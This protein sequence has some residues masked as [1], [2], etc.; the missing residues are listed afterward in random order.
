MRFLVH[1]GRIFTLLL[2]LF[3]FLGVSATYLYLQYIETK[4]EIVSIVQDSMLEK[5]Y[6]LLD[7]YIS[8][9]QDEFGE[10]FI[11]TLKTDATARLQAE[12]ALSLMKNSEVQFL[13]L[14]YIDE[15][16]RLRY[17]IDTTQGINEKGEYQQRFFPQKPIWVKAL[18]SK[19]PEV[20]TQKEIDKLWISMA[21]PIL[22][23]KQTVALLGIDFSHKEY[24]NVKETL[25]PLEN[26][27][28]YSALFIVIMLI[29]AFVQL[30]IY[31]KHRKKSFIDPL[32]G[33]FNRQY[34][35]EL[36]TKYA[37][38]DF[39][40]LI[41][42]L[43]HFKQVNDIYGHDAGD[44]VLRTVSSRIQSVIRKQD[45]LIRYGGEEFLLLISDKEVGLSMEIA[46][47]VR[48]AVK[49]T[50]I[51]LKDCKLKVTIS[52]GLNPFPERSK[53]FEQAVK[54]ADLGLYKAKKLGRDRVEIYDDN[55][56]L[57]DDSL[58]KMCDVKDALDEDNIF[59]V[60]QAIYDTKALAVE[61]YELLVRMK[62]KEGKVIFPDKFLPSIRFTQVYINITKRVLDFAFSALQDNDI[63][64]SINLDVQDLFNDEILNVFTSI[65]KT[66]PDIAKR[67]NIEI[68]VND[69]TIDFESMSKRLNILHQLGIKICLDNFGNGHSN[70]KHLQNMNIDSLKIDSAFISGIDTNKNAY[71]IVK[72]IHALAQE[73]GIKT[74]AE[75]IETKEEFDCIK[76]LG[77]DYVQGYYLSNPSKGFTKETSSR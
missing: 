65:F 73:L 62:D 23:D 45:I 15:T 39:Q 14:L 61:K 52:M 68:L 21:Y 70:Y 40:I 8:Y 3:P 9:L 19:S 7:L 12:T 37:V 4:K 10:D 76:T 71:I 36:L 22:K 11:T 27:Y 38:G 50:P 24:V 66:K 34:L 59:C 6:E 64:L 31:Y 32:T 77:I 57:D 17:L 63:S 49:V 42:D 56:S 48:Q 67:L 30:V 75:H 53:N 28:F 60:H 13:Y 43:D 29:S 1:Y 25:V 44:E 72:S 2:F 74:I 54:A 47:R 58:Q 20:A 26:I 16:N 18:Q 51:A 55:Q 69:D 41:M 46:Q 35:H 5:K 33:M